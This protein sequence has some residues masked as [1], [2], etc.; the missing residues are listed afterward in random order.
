MLD[1]DA[2]TTLNDLRFH[3]DDIYVID[4]QDGR[5]TAVP[6]SDPAVTISRDSSFE[7]REA[8]RV[9][10]AERKSGR[11]AGDSST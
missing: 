7:L 8:L 2:Q 11:W 3:W 6:L 10:Y 9:D 4:C 5:W 1:S